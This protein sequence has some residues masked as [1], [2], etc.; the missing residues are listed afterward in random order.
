[1]TQLTG[2]TLYTLHLLCFMCILEVGAFVLLLFFII[3]DA[4]ISLL[5]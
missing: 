3:N 5:K 2:S 4:N 1:M